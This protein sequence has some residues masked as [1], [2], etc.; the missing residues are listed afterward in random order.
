MGYYTYYELSVK[1]KKNQIFFDKDTIMAINE[2]VD[3]LD[4][5]ESGCVEDG[6]WYANA[7][8]YDHFEDMT[9]LSAKFPN[10]L[11]ELSGTGEEFGD[12]WVEYFC[13]GRSQHCDAEIVYEEPDME[14]LV[15]IDDSRDTD[16]KVDDSQL[17]TFLE[18]V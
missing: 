2:A 4:V 10:A 8:W 15:G 14:A 11:F 9:A 18:A 1:P 13:D 16:T 5:F 17:D 3:R 7:K 12:I 6:A